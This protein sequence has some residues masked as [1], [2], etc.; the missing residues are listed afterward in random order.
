MQDYFLTINKDGVFL[1]KNAAIKYRGEKLDAYHIQYAKR[2]F[3]IDSDGLVVKQPFAELY[4]MTSETAG[5]FSIGGNPSI[6]HGK[7]VWARAKSLGG[8]TSGWTYLCELK[9]PSEA[10]KFA[11][12][13]LMTGINLGVIFAKGKEQK[14]R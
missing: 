5:L 2:S 14:S 11:I 4:V 3:Y 9:N 10:A 13:S 12:S 6:K 1:G 7:H 8:A